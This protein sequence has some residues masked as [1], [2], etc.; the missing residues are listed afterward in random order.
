MMQLPRM[1]ARILLAF[2]CGLFACED[3]A[4]A[5]LPEQAI[6]GSPA[7]PDLALTVLSGTRS[8]PVD[9]PTLQ[10]R[11]RYAS[12]LKI[13]GTG[14][15]IRTGAVATGTTIIAFDKNGSGD[16][17]VK[18]GCATL[19]SIPYRIAAIGTQSYTMDTVTVHCR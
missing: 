7:P 14:L 3:N 18:V 12:A 11:W 1:R 6:P 5:P 8:A 15:D 9:S 4:T 16:S 13:A 19:D 2:V 17:T 10:I